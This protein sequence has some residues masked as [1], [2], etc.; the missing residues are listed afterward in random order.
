MSARWPFDEDVAEL[1][2]GD[3]HAVV[4]QRGA[5]A[6]A[7]RHHHHDAAAR[8]RRAEARLGDAGRVGVVE[9]DARTIGRPRRAA[10]P[11]AC[12]STLGSMC[13][14][15]R[16]MPFVTTAG[17]VQPIV[18]VARELAR[19]GRPRPP[20]TASGVAGCGVS[21]RIRPV[22]VTGAEVDERGLDAACRRRR[23][24]RAR[25]GDSG[26]DRH[27]AMNL[28][29]LGEVA[30]PTVRGS[31]GLRAPGRPADGRARVARRIDRLVVRAA[32][33]RAGVLRGAA[34]HARARPLLDRPD[35]RW[36]SHVAAGTGRTRWC[37]R[38][39]TRPTTGRV[40]VVDCLALGHA[41]PLLV[42]LVEGL[43]GTVDMA[44]EL[45]VRF[46][47]GSIVPWV[48]Q[49]DGRGARSPVPTASSCARRCDLHGRGQTSAAE[50]T[51]AAG[52]QVPFVLGWFPSHDP[53]PVPDDAATLVDA[54]DDALAAVVG[55]LRLLGRVARAGV[56]FAAHAGGADLRA[57]R[58]HRRRADHVVAGDAS[59]ARAT[60]TTATAGC[61]TRP[62]RSRRF[63]IGGYQ[64]R[65]AAL[66]RVAA[67]RG[68]G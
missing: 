37:S 46:D 58:R 40:R 10:S 13:V 31:R 54:H 19:R 42:R 20:T 33:R 38:P 50:F 34:R 47:Y 48:R 57:D 65:G 17:S 29:A 24:Q 7:D 15:V 67:A 49:V 22:A 36:R 35:R 51:V 8:A 66:A 63:L 23:H 27:R 2:V 41:R 18:P 55:A 60:G 4:E 53:R 26:S 68:R 11:R 43:E 59:A 12:R 52:E 25:V 28:A 5:D 9:H 14:A 1:G 6:G 16:T 45:V 64:R 62:S 30:F 61:A 21:T 32:L 44:V 3:Q 39:S 56:A